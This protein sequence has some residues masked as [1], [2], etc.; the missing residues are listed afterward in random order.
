MR[1]TFSVQSSD[2]S[3]VNFGYAQSRECSGDLVDTSSL[4]GIDRSLTDSSEFPSKKYVVEHSDV[5][6]AEDAGDNESK[7]RASQAGSN[8][9]HLT[10]ESGQ[11]RPANV[12]AQHDVGAC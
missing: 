4:S 10:V 11:R 5:S 2:R 1:S 6:S 7:T 8:V 9:C 3:L 12:R